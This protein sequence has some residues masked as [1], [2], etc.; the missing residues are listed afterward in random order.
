MVSWVEDASVEFEDDSL[1]VLVF[2][3]TC[4]AWSSKGSRKGKSDKSMRP[5]LISL[6]LARA[7]APDLILHECTLL[8]DTSLLTKFL[9]HVFKLISF[10]VSP[11]MLGWPVQRNRMYT[12]AV[13]MSTLSLTGDMIKYEA[14]HTTNKLKLK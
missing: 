3:S 8:F 9:S 7:L 6:F 10:V 4:K 12:I 2:G 5:F 14:R 1:K 13:N 11:Q